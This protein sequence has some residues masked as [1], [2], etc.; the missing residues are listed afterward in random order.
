[1]RKILFCALATLL[2]GGN[3]SVLSNRNDDAIPLKA[4]SNA[5]VRREIAVAVNLADSDNEAGLAVQRSMAAS[6]EKMFWA[7][8]VQGFLSLL[9]IGLVGWTLIHT[10][11]AANFAGSM[12]GEAKRTSEAAIATGNATIHSL[13]LAVRAQRPWVALSAVPMNALTVEVDRSSLTVELTMEN[14]G[15]TPATNVVTRFVAW[16]SKLGQPDGHQNRRDD[17]LRLLDQDTAGLGFALFPTER[18]SQT[19]G[20]EI[21]GLNQTSEDG[22]PIWL[23]AGVRYGFPGGIGRSTIVQFVWKAHPTTGG[24]QEI[25]S[26]DRSIPASSLSFHRMGLHESAD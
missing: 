4:N 25:T 9:G 5:S 23:I 7:A 19:Y 10:R 24:A 2:L 22:G 1:M 13:D 15:N 12:A 20:V 6:A 16:K 11:R 17:L 8:V 18:V 21:E 3:A 14:K 26:A